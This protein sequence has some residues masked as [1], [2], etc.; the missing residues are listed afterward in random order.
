VTSR[1]RNDE[2][3]P[4]GMTVER[5]LEIA[6]G[7]LVNRPATYDLRLDVEI[8]KW[9]AAKES[10]YVIADRLGLTRSMVARRRAALSLLSNGNNNK[11]RGNQCP[12]RS[13]PRP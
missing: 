10:D 2:F 1:K 5:A 9:H 6:D 12:V 13:Q 3:H 4:A 11:K 7:V 8:R